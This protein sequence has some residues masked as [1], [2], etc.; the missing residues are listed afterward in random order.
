LVWGSDW[1]HPT[2]ANKPNDANMMDMLTRW[3][4]DRSVI[5][6]ILVSNPAALYGFE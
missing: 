4:S 3:T 1:P 2:E 5:E 6:Q